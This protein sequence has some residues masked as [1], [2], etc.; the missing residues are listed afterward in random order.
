M[1]VRELPVF[2]TIIV[3]AAVATMIALGFW[4]LGRL[5]E[6]EAQL[7]FYTAA[8]NDRSE[9]AYPRDE[10]SLQAALYR[11][12]SLDCAQ[13]SAVRSVSGTSDNGRSG[14]AHKASCILPDGSSGEVAL[15]WSRDPQAPEYAG[16]KVTG[17]IAPGGRIV[18]DPPLAGLEPL[19]K[20][21]PADIPNNHL[22]Y[23]GQW[24]FF[25]LTALV[26]YFL[27]V[28]RRVKTVSRKIE[29]A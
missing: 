29:D 18:A 24:F 1:N 16:G 5:D 21:D 3:L 4:Q 8:Q 6:K 11:R 17:I 9:V 25:A 15:G 14:W 2:S 10:A 26:I 22:A 28:R 27:A 13:V 7:A 23:A 20:P 19:A 12:S